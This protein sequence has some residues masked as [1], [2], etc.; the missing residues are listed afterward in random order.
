[1]RPFL[2]VSLILFSVVS[3]V[4]QAKADEI[5]SWQDC[6]REAAQN[7]PDLIAAQEAIEQSKDSKTIAASALFPQVSASARFSTSQTETAGNSHS[8]LAE[9]SGS[10]LVFDGFKTINNTYT[11]RENI[12]AAKESFRFTSSQVRWR[13]RTAFINLLKAQASERLAEDIHKIRRE[14]LQ[15]ITLRYESGTEH[16]GA[17]LTAQAQLASAEFDMHQSGR[18]VT[19]AQ[20]ELTK[21]MGR[22]DFVPF[23]VQGDFSVSENLEEKPD[24]EGL[25]NRHPSLLKTVAQKNAAAYDVKSARGGFFPTVTIDGNA[26]K[27]GAAWPP[28]GNESGVGL[29]FSVPLFE[30]GLKAAEL[31]QSKSV[32]RQFVATEQ[33]T[34]DGILFSL[35]Q[36]WSS[37][38]DA[39]EN[40]GVQQKFLTATEERS[41]I[42]ESQYSVGIISYDNWTIIEDDLVRQKK[43]FL[44]AQASALKAQADWIEAKG[45]T[46]EYEK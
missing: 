1:M 37:L 36:T 40:I 39:V 17:L 34:K 26:G 3:F 4:G 14:N 8:S 12:K 6:L 15:L 42:A 16:K 27:S 46:L 22:K 35:Q 25:A 10:Q 23:S 5:L 13:L 9:F 45:E 21:E 7:H 33:S 30:G 31:A 44:D 18:N 11:A 20:Q 38:Q 32:Y 29:R 2:L 41:K 43:T 28:D 24:F 19:V